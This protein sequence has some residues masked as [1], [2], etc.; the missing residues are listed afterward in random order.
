MQRARR[1]EQLERLGGL[2]KTVGVVVR[3]P[4]T[5][6]R[7]IAHDADPTGVGR[8]F[9]EDSVVFAFLVDTVVVHAMRVMRA[10]FTVAAPLR[11]ST[12][13]RA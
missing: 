8:K 3:R 1:A 12:N 7:R 2:A 13:Q 10:L 5:G 11:R 6:V 4:P 9:R